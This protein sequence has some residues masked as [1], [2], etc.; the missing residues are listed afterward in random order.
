MKPVI[1]IGCQVVTL[2]NG[3]RVVFARRSAGG[4][5]STEN[6]KWFGVKSPIKVF[7]GDSVDIVRAERSRLTER[8]ERSELF[9]FNFGVFAYAL[10]NFGSGVIWFTNGLVTQEYWI[11][12]YVNGVLVR[13]EAYT[14]GLS[15]QH[16]SSEYSV[17]GQTYEFVVIL[18]QDS[19]KFVQ[20][21]TG[22]DSVTYTV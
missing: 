18:Y 4:S 9:R 2:D 3:R 13:D 20:L 21:R 16:F 22:T 11:E 6:G 15:G 19:S 17:S 8:S 5:R 7:Q 10:T 12:V 1:G 14:A